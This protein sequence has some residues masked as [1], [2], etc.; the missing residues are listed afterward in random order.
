MT[1]HGHAGPI[2]SA[3]PATYLTAHGTRDQLDLVIDLIEDLA[4]V[5]IGIMPTPCEGDPDSGCRFMEA[6]VIG[7]VTAEQIR[8][9]WLAA[10]AARN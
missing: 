3:T 7:E 6:A 8:A 5:A 4:S 1:I 9:A 2:V 10:I